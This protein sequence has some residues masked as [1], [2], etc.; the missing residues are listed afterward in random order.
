M[1]LFIQPCLQ[2][3]LAGGKVGIGDT[4]LLEAK[5]STTLFYFLRLLIDLEGL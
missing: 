3:R 5:L 2:F 4:D 1:V